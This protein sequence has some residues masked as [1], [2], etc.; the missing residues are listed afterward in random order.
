MTGDRDDEDGAADAGAV[1]DARDDATGSTADG[2]DS[3]VD[4]AGATDDG[5][6]RTCDPTAEGGDAVGDGRQK[7]VEVL[8]AD[9]ERHEHGDAYLRQSDEVFLVSP[10]PT[11]PAGDTVTYRK[12]EVT[13]VSVEQHHSACFITTAVAGEERTLAA[14]RGFRDGTLERSPL[15]RPLVALYER[16]SP[17]VA[18]TLAARPDGPTAR[19]VRGLVRRCAGLARRRETATPPMRSALTVLLVALYVV[20]VAVAA[21]GHLAAAVGHGEPPE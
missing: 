21:A 12:T 19:V 3:P 2:A 14:L 18:A 6:D 7:Y 5:G 11:F 13:R 10:E 8:T 15:G 9:G 16:V 17:P 4:E 1:D 20:G